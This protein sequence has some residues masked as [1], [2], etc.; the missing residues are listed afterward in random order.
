MFELFADNELISSSQSGFKPGDSC[1]NQLL[2]ITHDIFQYFDDSLETKAVFLDISKAIDK[3]WHKGLLY[4]FRENGI[5]CNLL[6]IIKD[7]LSLR[8][9]RVVLNG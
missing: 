1:F 2:Y 7:F 6:N 3:I 4:K 5:L 8:R 9:Q